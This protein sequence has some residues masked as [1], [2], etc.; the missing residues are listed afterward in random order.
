MPPEAKYCDGSNVG[1]EVGTA[2]AA[3]YYFYALAH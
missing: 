2:Y 3:D 1:K